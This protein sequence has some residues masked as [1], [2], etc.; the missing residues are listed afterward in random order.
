MQLK[1]VHDAEVKGKRVLLRVDFNVPIEAGVIVDDARIRAALPTVNFLHEAGAAKITVATHLGRP[2]GKEVGSLKVAPLEARLKELAPFPEIEML[3]NLRFNP[4]EEANDPQFAQELA[5]HGEVFVN[6]AF[7]DAHRAHA[8]IVGVAKLLPS[9]AGLL[10]LKEVENLSQALAPQ[11]PA[12]AIVGGAKFETKIPLLT[13]LLTI[14]DGVLLG[15]ALASEL[16]LARGLPVGSSLLSGAGVPEALAGNDALVV[17]E[18]A[19]LVTVDTTAGRTSL[20]NDIRANEKIVDIGT[21]TIEAWQKKIEGAE[22]VLWNGPVG[23]YEESYVDGTDALAEALVKSGA[24]AVIG[25]GDTEAALKKIKFDPAKVY[26]STGG[27][28]MLEFLADGTLPGLEVLR[29]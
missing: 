7:A 5:Q 3:E 27:G 2:G 23:I 19:E 20:I 15:G 1:S 6:D 11:K 22:F 18:D 13:K 16:L 26:V 29:A 10:M 8:S 24:R 12:L 28:A 17:P 21:R 25:G 14:Y 4:G 9:Y